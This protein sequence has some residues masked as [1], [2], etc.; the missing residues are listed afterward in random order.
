M[1]LASSRMF[2]Q[3]QE[4]FRLTSGE[5]AQFGG[6]AQFEALAWT[7]QIAAAPLLLG[8]DLAFETQKDIVR[9][10]GEQLRYRW[11]EY[12][13]DALGILPSFTK[14]NTYYFDYSF[15]LPLLYA[16][17]QVRAF[18]Q[19]RNTPQSARSSTPSARLST[20]LAFLSGQKTKLKFGELRI[21]ESWDLL[22]NA[23]RKIW[24]RSAME[25]IRED[26]QREGEFLKTFEDAPDNARKCFEDYHHLR[27]TL[28]DTLEKT[29]DSILDTKTFVTGLLPRLQPGMIVC[30][31]SGHDGVVAVGRDRLHHRPV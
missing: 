26:Y 10:G 14:D 8:P 25:E 4:S 22:N 27:G 21:A 7:Y 16:S 1:L 20:L 18:G 3:D 5:Y 30:K 24:G 29:P 31:A 13:A 12:I 6:E 9:F 28:I 23:C 17:L 2:A 19:T 15:T 11:M